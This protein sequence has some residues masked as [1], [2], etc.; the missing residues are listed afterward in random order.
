VSITSPANGATFATGTNIAISAT[1]SD[2][3]GSITKVEFYRGS[4][5]IGSDTTSPYSV[6]WSS[7][8]AGSYALTAVAHDNGG[9]STAT[10]AVNITV[11][12]ATV[13][14]TKVAFTPSA[15]HSSSVTSYS[16]AIRRAGT[17]A[18]TTPVATKSLGKPT[19]SNNEIL[20][21]ISDI[22]N[23]LASGTYYAIVTAIGSGGS[24][25]SA[26]SPNFTK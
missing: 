20:V 19:P 16:V 15:D 7:A 2:S 9:A 1:A 8:T 4:T 25:A 10:A 17:S 12:T 21:D 6:T 5:L 13:T 26:P 23:P 14:P 24:S 22:V 11:G 18:T 3:N